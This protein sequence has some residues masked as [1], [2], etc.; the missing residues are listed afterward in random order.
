MKKDALFAFVVVALLGFSA[1]AAFYIAPDEQTMH[2]VQRIFYLHAPCGMT[3]L[4]AFFAGFVGN[5]AYLLKRERK[6]DSLGV[7]G[8]EVGLAFCTVVLLTGPIWAKPAWGVWWAWDA[9]LTSTLVLW[10]LYVS[11]LLLRTMIEDSERR[12]LVS[13]FYGVFS[14]LDVPLVYGSI[15]WWRTQHPQPVVFTS[16]GLDPTMRKVFYLS[17]LSLTLLMVLLIRKR[18]ELEEL[19]F[20][21]QTLEQEAE[22]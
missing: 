15:W 6:W 9:R 21:V 12:A 1:Y 2:L 18:Y 22:A 17:W 11:Y 20:E 13:A 19:R 14:F 5:V 16:G 7:A 4:V 10:L 8:A 3:A